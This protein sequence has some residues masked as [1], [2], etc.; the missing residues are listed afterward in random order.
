MSHAHHGHGRHHHGHGGHQ[1]GPG[2]AERGFAP[3]I[4]LNLGFVALEAG[5]GLLAGSLALLADAGHN[6]SDVLGLALAWVA[7]RLARRRPS[8]RRTYGFHRGTILAALGNAV[9][10]LV[11]VGAIGLESAR[12]LWQP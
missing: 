1:H 6:L 4:A 12:R 9:L 8:A 5:A 3:G 2:P 7:A 11:A 10:L